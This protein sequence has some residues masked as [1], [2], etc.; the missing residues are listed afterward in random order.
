M[1]SFRAVRDQAQ[2]AAI[3]NRTP[4]AE[5]QSKNLSAVNDAT[6][7]LFAI[8]MSCRPLRRC[9][10]YKRTVTETYRRDCDRNY[11]FEELLRGV[12]VHGTVG[13]V[14]TLNPAVERH[15]PNCSLHRRALENP[16][17]VSRF[18]I[19]Q[20]NQRRVVPGAGNC[21]GRRHSPPS[22]GTGRTRCKPIGGMHSIVII[23]MNIK[24]ISGWASR[25]RKLA[26]HRMISPTAENFLR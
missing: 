18:C 15:R 17:D 4:E 8:E 22:R 7:S 1:A 10:D 23:S 2:R 25:R 21:I 14:L 12:E 20:A 6:S 19:L 13:R 3:A 24:R 26:N 11:T 16:L 5:A 9:F